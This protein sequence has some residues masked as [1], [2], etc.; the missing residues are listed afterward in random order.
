[1]GFAA[2]L[3]IGSWILIG[4]LVWL[5]YLVTRR[6]GKALTAYR[7]LQQRVGYLEDLIG[8]TTAPSPL[9]NEIS[10]EDTDPHVHDDR[11][12]SVQAR[13]FRQTTLQRN[14]LPAGMKAPDFTLPDLTGRRRSLEEFRGTRVMLV[15][16][17]PNCG[18]CQLLAPQLEEV[19]QRHEQNNLV[20]LMVSRGEASINK[21]KA[22]EQGLRFPILLQRQWEVSKAYAMFATTIGYLIDENGVLASNVAI[23]ADAILG[24]SA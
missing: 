2:I 14:G 10:H 8:R 15:F 24:L 3:L 17:D 23:G 13:R 9:T 12:P 5:L 4:G 7:L 20:V 16:S 11:G 21:Q 6:H 22:A 1:M 19:Y 18:P